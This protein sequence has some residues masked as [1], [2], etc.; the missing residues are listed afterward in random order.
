MGERQRL[1]II[2]GVFA[3][4]P[5]CAFAT[6]VPAIAGETADHGLSYSVDGQSYSQNPPP[7]FKDVHAL[8]PGDDVEGSLWIR[9]DRQSAIELGVQAVPPPESTEIYFKAAG[10]SK[11]HLEPADATEVELRLGLP[12]SAGNDSEDQIVPGLE[13]RV[14]AMEPVASSEPTQRPGPSDDSN[15]HEGDL[16]DTG[17]NLETL[18]ASLALAM[19]G[20][21]ALIASRR[22]N[23]RHHEKDGTQ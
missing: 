3:V 16:L 22:R 4:A 9:N 6:V 12:L 7:I 13:V 1:K 23:R 15:D 21:V 19:L 14:H 2:I 10:A 17:V 18:W 11:F 20:S 5:C 8:V